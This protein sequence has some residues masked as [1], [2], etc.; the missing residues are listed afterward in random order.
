MFSSHLVRGGCRGA[1]FAVVRGGG[2][3]V[4]RGAR[5]TLS[6]GTVAAV[7]AGLVDRHDRRWCRFQRLL[8]VPSILK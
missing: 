2:S 7:A 8:D 4:L 3:A 1:V 5:L 6:S